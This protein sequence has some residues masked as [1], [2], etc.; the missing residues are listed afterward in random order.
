MSSSYADIVIPV[1]AYLDAMRS[2]DDDAMDDYRYRGFDDASMPDALVPEPEL[3]VNDYGVTHYEAVT[4][5]TRDHIVGNLNPAQADAVTLDPD[6]G[7]AMILS[8][9]GTGKTTVLTRRIAYLKAAGVDPR[10]ILAVTFTNKAANEMEMRLVGL[11]VSP[12][13]VVGTFHSIGLRIVKACPEA[14]GVKAGFTIMDDYDQK[15]FWKR[16]FVRPEKSGKGDGDDKKAMDE[17]YLIPAKSKQRIAIDMRTMM[18][19]KDEGIRSSSD[20]GVAGFDAKYATMLDIYESERKQRNLVDFSDLISA[21]LNA[22]RNY[23]E[24]REFASRFTHVLVDEFQD[25]SRLQFDWVRSITEHC[26]VRNIY[27]VGDDCQSIY[28]FRG[29]VVENIEDFITKDNAIEVRLEQNYRCGSRILDIANKLIAHNPGGDKKKLWSDS[30][31]KGDISLDSYASDLNEASAIAKRLKDNPDIIDHSAILLRQREPIRTIT[32]ELRKHGIAYTV[33]GAHDFFDSKEVRTLTAMLKLAANPRDTESFV[34]V[35]GIM[36]GVGKTSIDGMIEQFK[37]SENTNLINLC[38]NHKNAG[39][40]NIFEMYQG[41]CGTTGDVP[42]AVCRFIFYSG[43]LDECV[44]EDL[45]EEKERKFVRNKP[46]DKGRR[47]TNLNE[48]VIMSRNAKDVFAFIDELTLF[49]EKRKKKS[50]VIVSTIHSA[51]GLEWDHVFLPALNE[52]SFFRS[53]FKQDDE[54]EENDTDLHEERR[55]M[56]VALTR[57]KQSIFASCTKNRMVYGK[58][59]PTNPCRFI[60]ESGLNRYHPSVRAKYDQQAIT[61][62]STMRNNGRPRA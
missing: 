41:V 16:L 17:R 34:R 37:K 57:A 54:E 3:A 31:V 48:F 9:A 2:S 50:G 40:K 43:L 46:T 38:N 59:V 58:I 14:A 21:S 6:C 49:A 55:L 53:N 27:A 51:K 10:R 12:M 33:F 35:A 18:R 23:P 29:A 13:P 22:V 60:Y 11:G 15:A 5:F 1:E 24:G 4:Q 7:P 44:K 25:T 32:A 61:E 8:G 19:M 62:E 47:E 28:G 30:G 20:P 42:L 56:Y 36:P 45:K 52:Q 39:L 26:L